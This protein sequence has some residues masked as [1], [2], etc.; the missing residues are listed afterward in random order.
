MYNKAISLLI[1]DT[2][3]SIYN[4]IIHDLYQCAKYAL[5]S[6]NINFLIY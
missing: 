5:L 6:Q 2:N 1:I 3:N 4:Q